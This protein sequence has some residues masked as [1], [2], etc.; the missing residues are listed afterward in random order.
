MKTIN[1]DVKTTGTEDMFKKNDTYQ[2]N[3]DF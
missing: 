1:M 2:R 3:D